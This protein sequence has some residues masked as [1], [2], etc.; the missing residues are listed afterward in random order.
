MDASCWF[1]LLSSGPKIGCTP[2]TAGTFRKKF[3]KTSGKTTET[4]SERFLEFPSRVRLGYPKPYN[5]RCS[6]LPEHFQNSLPPPSTAG[7]AL[8]F[9][10]WFRRVPLRAGHGIP[11]STGGISERKPWQLETWQDS[12][13]AYSPKLH[14]KPGETGK[15]STGENS[16]NPVE[17]VPQNCRFLSLVVVERASVKLTS[18]W[19]L[20]K[21]KPI[22][23][24]K[25]RRE[26]PSA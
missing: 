2:S 5:S 23:G 16:E 7:D 24:R 15:Q 22:S 10:K 21:K 3:Q 4:L 11:S 18:R 26:I 12:A 20:K 19:N 13:C 8:F 25:N 1:Y 6:R 9:Q 14:W 17:T